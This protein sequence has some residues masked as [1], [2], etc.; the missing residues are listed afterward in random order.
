M[1]AELKIECDW[2]YELISKLEVMFK[3]MMLSNSLNGGF[4]NYISNNNK[5]MQGV[6][7]TVR[8]LTKGY[9]PGLNAP[10][11]INLVRNPAFAYDVF[12]S[13]YMSKHSGRIL[14]LQPRAGTADLNALFYGNKNEDGAGASTSS[15][16][17]TA[18]NVALRKHIICVNTYQ[19]V[20]LMLLN[21]RQKMTFDELKEET[22]IPEQ[23]LTR[24]LQPLALGKASQRILIKHPK[25]KEIEGSHEFSVNENFSSQLYRIKIQQASARQ[26]EAEPERNETKKK[27]EEDRKHEI[28][29]CIVR[30]MKSR[31]Q[32]DHNQL[33]TEV[34]AQL[35]KRFQP[36][37]VVIKKRIEGLIEREYIKRSDSDRKVY[38]YLA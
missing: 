33:V 30:I 4:K 16:N 22:S 31:K 19:M 38:V 25:S 28:E 14:T 23:E 3:D 36:S 11:T 2:Q 13:F 8:V 5:N 1:I 7:L 34:V 9:W 20:L 18:S 32:L 15:N 6:D 17:D 35:S 24:A 37:P 26:G 29:A 27:V 10:P 21:N 12:K